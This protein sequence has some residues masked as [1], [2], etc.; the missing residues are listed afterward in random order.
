MIENGTRIKLNMPNEDETAVIKLLNRIGGEV[1]RELH[2]RNDRIGYLVAY[3]FK[4]IQAIDAARD[5]DEKNG[6]GAVFFHTLGKQ[7]PKEFPD[8]ERYYLLAFESEVQTA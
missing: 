3:D 1:V 6:L 2:I 8:D 4:H 7:R 5:L